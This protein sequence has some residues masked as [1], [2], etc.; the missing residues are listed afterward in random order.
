MVG[1]FVNELG[2]F[3]CDDVVGGYAVKV[4]FTWQANEVAPVWRQFFSYDLGSTW[5]LNWEMTFI[6]TT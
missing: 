4:R 1:Q 2:T 3:E 5:K 6:R